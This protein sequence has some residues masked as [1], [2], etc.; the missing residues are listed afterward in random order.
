MVFQ[1]F[2][3][4]AQGRV[5]AR[6]QSIEVV[7]QKVVVGVDIYRNHLE[8]VPDLQHAKNPEKVPDVPVR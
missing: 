7:V 5:E 6:K 8:A 4:R 3:E 1:F 2:D